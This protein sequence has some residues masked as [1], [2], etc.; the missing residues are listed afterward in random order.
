[1]AWCYIPKGVAKVYFAS[2]NNKKIEGWKDGMGLWNM[3]P[4]Q[5]FGIMDKD[6]ITMTKTLH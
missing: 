5:R 4:W 3:I 1:M 2:E 6:F